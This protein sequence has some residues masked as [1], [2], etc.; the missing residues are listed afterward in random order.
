VVL[1]F[2][3]VI[4]FMENSYY[5]SHSQRKENSTY[6]K[7]HDLIKRY[8]M[9]CMNFGLRQ[10][11]TLVFIRSLELGIDARETESTRFQNLFF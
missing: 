3:A 10:I 2:L 5:F 6:L 8:S 4:I 11:D 7:L 9:V 1:I